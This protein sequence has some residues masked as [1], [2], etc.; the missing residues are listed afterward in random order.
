M[1]AV[2]QL[3]SGISDDSS[4]SQIGPFRL[5][6]VEWD[7]HF[8]DNKFEFNFLPSD[9][10][11]WL[12]Q[13]AVFALMAHR[14]L[15]AFVSRESRAPSVKELYLQQWPDA[16]TATFPEN[17]QNALDS[18][19]ALVPPAAEAVLDEPLLQ[20][21]IIQSIDQRTL[22]TPDDLRRFWNREPPL[23]HDRLLLPYRYRSQ[24]AD[25]RAV[26]LL[27]VTGRAPS[28]ELSITDFTGERAERLTFG[29]A[30]VHVP[31]DHKIGQL[32]LPK[33]G[34]WWRLRFWDEDDDPAG[35]FILEKVGVF[36]QGTFVSIV[37]S[38]PT[39]TAIVFIHGFNTSF[40]EGVLRFA[41]IIWDM[42]FKGVPVLF[43]WPSRGGV[44]SYLYDWNSALVARETFKKLIT[45]L[46]VE[47]KVKTLHVIAHSM[48]NLIMLE[49]LS[50]VA[51][52]A[53]RPQLS[54]IVMA[55]PDVDI[56]LFNILANKVRPFAEGM[57]LYASANDKALVTSRSVAGKPRA[58]DVFPDGPIVVENIDSVD[59]SAIGDEMFGLNHNVFATNR[60][61]IDDIG[62][63]VLSGVRPPHVRSPQIRR[64]PEGEVQPRYW[65]YPAG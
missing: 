20:L 46:R 64:V 34:N 48:G 33:K 9:I 5:T 38:D 19:A 51:N 22:L 55:A 53:L 16:A 54:E 13:I 15:D 6:Q 50:Q 37:E 62:R 57:T 49:S 45:L 47:A 65:L 44:L 18:T 27:F 3:R 29:S 43:S 35:H 11:D 56:D 17:F 52:L 30:R 42:Q 59:V 41:Q 7:A 8:I 28:G 40:R 58:G 21:S 36:D 32:E 12:R 14:A 39:H 63:L 24:I 10:N 2:A 1:L 4:D 61:L 23:L 25:P 26:E 60:S 31:K